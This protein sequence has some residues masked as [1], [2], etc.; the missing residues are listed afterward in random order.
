LA[1]SYASGLYALAA[2]SAAVAALWLNIPRRSVQA[3]AAE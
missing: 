1:G 3:V 2:M